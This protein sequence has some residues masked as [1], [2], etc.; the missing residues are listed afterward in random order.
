MVDCKVGRTPIESKQNFNLENQDDAT[1]V[2][3]QQLVGSLM[4]LAVLTRPDI[5][6]SVSFFSQ[7]PLLS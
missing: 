5:A 2:P 6:F 1:E 3:Y 4:Y 7:F